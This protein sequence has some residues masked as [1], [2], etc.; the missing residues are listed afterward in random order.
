[1]VSANH[2]LYPQQKAL[3]HSWLPAKVLGYAYA[4]FRKKEGGGEEEEE[5]HLIIVRLSLC[6]M[7]HLPTLS[8]LGGL[9]VS[10]RA[11]RGLVSKL[12][13]QRTPQLS[14]C[15]KKKFKIQNIS[16]PWLEKL[17]SYA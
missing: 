13:S 16:Y 11:V 6:V 5:E 17:S 15:D 12:S 4:T 3:T 2:S 9:G 14:W 10:F 7:L 8:R 1:M